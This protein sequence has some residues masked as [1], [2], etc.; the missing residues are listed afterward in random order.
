MNELD[1]EMLVEILLHLTGSVND[2][3]AI[4]AMGQVCR[5]LQGIACLDQIWHPIWKKLCHPQWKDL[6]IITER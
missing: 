6:T 4:S 3:K 5:R 2:I 1:P